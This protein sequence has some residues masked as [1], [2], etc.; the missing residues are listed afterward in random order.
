MTEERLGP[1]EIVRRIGVGGMAEVMLARRPGPGG[2]AKPVALK[3]LLPEIARDEEVRAMFVEEAR[4]QATLSH[5]NL[6]QVFDF[7]EEDGEHFLVMEYV[8]GTDLAALLSRTPRLDPR[9]ALQIAA[10]VGEG[11]AYLHG[12]GIVHRDVSPGNVYLSAAGE[13]KLG[14]FGIAK[15]RA[16]ALRTERGRLKGKLAYLSPEQARGETADVRADVYA[17][18]LVLFEMLS[19]ERYLRGDAEADLLRAAMDPQPRSPGVGEPADAL[20]R[21]LLEPQREE[22]LPTA[23][24]AAQA[25]RQTQAALGPV[26]GHAEL[27]ALVAGSAPPGP[28]RVRLTAP[29]QGTERLP[30]GR[31]RRWPWAVAAIG[32]LAI[33]SLASLRSQREPRVAAPV[34]ATPETVAVP[35]S[36][37][38]PRPPS[39]SIE[40]VQKPAPAPPPS[41]ARRTAV[42]PAKAAKPPGKAA[43]AEAP[44]PVAA[45]APESTPTPDASSPTPPRLERK[46]I[47]DRLAA[48]GARLQGSRLDAR[49]KERARRLA[50]QALSH[51]M[52]RRYGEAD[53]LLDDLEALLRSV[54]DTPPP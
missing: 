36:L 19:G 1:Y 23:K 45:P 31:A 53:R 29:R 49:D 12:R 46:D 35:T 51:T 30:K 50:Q 32:L 39:P 18:G 21:R 15:G 27:A 24:L 4:L 9:V 2:F 47:E 26:P 3:R 28:A 42:R 34:E 41:P 37:P 38:E 20:V 7:G 40:P 33:A 13:V 54:K 10:E 16:A 52:E 48:L 5:R 43:H 22:R 25:I 44:E 17:L 14:D 8:E 11:L 6:V